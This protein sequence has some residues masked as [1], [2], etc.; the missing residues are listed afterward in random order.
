MG[1]SVF[2]KPSTPSLHFQNTYHPVKKISL[3]PKLLT[4]TNAKHQNPTLTPCH[5]LP[6]SKISLQLLTLCTPVSQPLNTSSTVIAATTLSR[7]SAMMKRLPLTHSEVK[8]KRSCC[9]LY[10]F[11][12]L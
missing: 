10:H 12:I 11:G 2:V 6:T 7:V 3:S 8:L 4:S 1:I 9:T 5:Q